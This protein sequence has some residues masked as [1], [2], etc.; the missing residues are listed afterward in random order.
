LTQRNQVEEYMLFR[1]VYG[2]WV[3]GN[4][5]PTHIRLHIHIHINAQETKWLPVRKEL[6]SRN[7]KKTFIVS[8]IFPQWKCGKSDVVTHHLKDVITCFR[9]SYQNDKMGKGDF[10]FKE[11]LLF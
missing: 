2:Q 9:S 11:F 3:Y 6:G 4:K 10:F 5:P 1:W 7:N 8:E